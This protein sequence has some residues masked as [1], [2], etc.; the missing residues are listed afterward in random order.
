MGRRGPD[1][2][3]FVHYD[4]VTPMFLGQVWGQDVKAGQV[5]SENTMWSG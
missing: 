3:A 4:V 1:L 2:P 5:N